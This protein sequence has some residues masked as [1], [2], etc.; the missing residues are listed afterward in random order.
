MPICCNP[1]IN[2]SGPRTARKFLS[3]MPI[4][5]SDFTVYSGSAETFVADP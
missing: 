3:F 1:K 4:F 5:Y 2:F